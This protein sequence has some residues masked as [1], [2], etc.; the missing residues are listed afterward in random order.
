MGLSVDEWHILSI[1]LFPCLSSLGITASIFISSANNR[2]VLAMGVMFSAGV[3]LSAALVHMLPH[4]AET[5]DLHFADDDHASHDDGG[6]VDD[7]HLRD[8]DHYDLFGH[9]AHDDD[10][11]AH[12]DTD[13]HAGHDHRYLMRL[14][15]H[16]SHDDAADPHAGHNHAF[17]W[18]QTLFSMAFIVL[19]CIEATMERFID[20]YFAGKRGN[21][22]HIEEEEELMYAQGFAADLEREK[23]ERK[24]ILDESQKAPSVKEEAARENNCDKLHDYG[25]KCDGH[26]HDHDHATSTS[27]DEAENGVKETN[28]TEA[29]KMQDEE[30]TNETEAETEKT[31]TQPVAKP[32]GAND[33]IK[34]IYPDCKDCQMSIDAPLPD[35]KDCILTPAELGYAEPDV[36]HRHHHHNN[37][38]KR[39][40]GSAQGDNRSES[41]RSDALPGG[42][43]GQKA[44]R[45]NS[46]ATNASGKSSVWAKSAARPSVVSFGVTPPVDEPDVQQTINPWVSILLTLVLSIHVVLEGLTIGSS[47]DVD[48]I[49]STFVAVA[50]HK[51]FA[52]F[53][54]GSSLVASGYWE[55]NRNMFFILAGTFV[56]V[57]IV[58]IGIGM[59]ISDLY[60]QNANIVGAVLQSLLGGSFLFV[61]TVELIPGE[62][63]KMRRHN[64]PL[65]PILMCLCLGFALMTMLS[66][67]GV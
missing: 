35:C 40:T 52:S 27:N 47:Q 51:V 49:R 28:A 12:D 58:S 36:H 43:F 44:P 64:L 61:S 57:D 23:K 39:N 60:D 22:F 9:G 65:L 24:D 32:P 26:G 20:V 50:S 48:T 55:S 34:M 59:A 2:T 42:M 41:A 45:R 25:E 5:L 3:L 63:E 15:Q 14:L 7:D 30:K 6:H 53:S 31:D 67:W 62:L 17:P 10:T 4:A 21:F 37:L 11:G 54:L 56:A 13:D 8:D 29:P 66:K 16:D 1:C 19:L 18:A 38:H 46:G 33:N